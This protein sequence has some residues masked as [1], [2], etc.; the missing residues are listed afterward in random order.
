MGGGAK[1][2][3]SLARGG[4]EAAQS[5]V[6]AANTLAGVVSSLAS[7][8]HAAGV[9]T[10]GPEFALIGESGTE[11]VIPTT[12]KRWDLLYGVMKEYGL[13]VPKAAR[14]GIFNQ[15]ALGKLDRTASESRIVLE[16]HTVHELYIDG[17]K[18]TDIFMKTAQ[19]KIKARQGALSNW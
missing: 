13:R 19:H 16:D 17:K 7:N 14:G 18:V 12:T 11:Y 4:A 9:K 6:S 8:G 10:T 2:G 1:A 3:A 5:I 15:S